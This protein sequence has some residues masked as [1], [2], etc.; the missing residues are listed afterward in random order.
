MG[1]GQKR[2]TEQV[3]LKWKN[4]KARAT[5]ATMLKQ[6]TSPNKPFRRGDYTDVVLDIRQ[7]FKSCL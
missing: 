7:T 5:K 3:K 1:S 4:L 6:K 2:T